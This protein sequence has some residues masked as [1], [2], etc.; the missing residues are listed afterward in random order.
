MGDCDKIYATQSNL[1]AHVRE[2]H[3]ATTKAH[4]CKTCKMRFKRT[5]LKRHL[6]VHVPKS[7]WNLVCPTC[8]KTCA[9]RRDNFERHVK[10]CAKPKPSAPDSPVRDDHAVHAEKHHEHVAGTTLKRQYRKKKVKVTKRYF[11]RKR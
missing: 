2:D 10:S 9:G 8:L 3:N 5:Y 6:L 7:N 4:V 11:L 1:N